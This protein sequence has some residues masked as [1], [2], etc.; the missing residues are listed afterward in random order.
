MAEPARC[1]GCAGPSRD[2]PADADGYLRCAACGLRYAPSGSAPRERYDDAY[3]TR[4]CGG[5]YFATEPL[6]RHEARVRLRLVRG[7]SGAAATDLLEVGCAAGFFLDEARREGWH[8]RGIEPAQGPARYARR[9]LG[10]DVVQGFAEDVE[11][12]AASLDAICL[13]HTLEHIPRPEALLARLREALRPG[14]ALFVE[15][16]NGASLPA[17]R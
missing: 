16:P 6:R 3:F 14:G 12:P 11:L 5:D 7:V 15:V 9:E 17:I 4:Y 1:W 13:W 8:P 2:E 10:L